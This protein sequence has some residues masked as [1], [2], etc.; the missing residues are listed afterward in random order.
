MSISDNPG[1][2]LSTR[3][4]GQLT[5]TSTTALGMFFKTVANSLS[6]SHQKSSTSVWF[7]F[8]LPSLVAKKALCI[9]YQICVGEIYA[10]S[11]AVTNSV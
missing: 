4:T 10:F 2:F 9:V 5:G 3:Q 6:E 8:A 7:Q 1:I 11:S